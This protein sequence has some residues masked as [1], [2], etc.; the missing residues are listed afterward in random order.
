MVGPK[1]TIFELS[2]PVQTLILT[3]AWIIFHTR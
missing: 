1:W 2:F 3:G